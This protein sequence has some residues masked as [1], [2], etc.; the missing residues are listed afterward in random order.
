MS[1]CLLSI[2][3]RVFSDPFMK[4]TVPYVKARLCPCLRQPALGESSLAARW[5]MQ[6]HCYNIL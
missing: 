2:F 1:G 3:L 5:L 4:L 6:H